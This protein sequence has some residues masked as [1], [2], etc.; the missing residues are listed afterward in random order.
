M[1]KLRESAFLYKIYCEVPLFATS[2]INKEELIFRCGELVSPEV[3]S[4]N[5]DVGNNKNPLSFESA[6]RRYV[7]SE[8]I[9]FVKSG[10][11]TVSENG[12]YILML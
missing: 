9:H 7:N 4:R 2:G 11:L 3:I 5:L 10:R 1:R 8:I 6:K 12:N